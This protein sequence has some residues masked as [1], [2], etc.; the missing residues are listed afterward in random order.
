MRSKPGRE[1]ALIHLFLSA[2]EDGAWAD[3]AWDPVERHTPGTVEGIATRSDGSTLAIEHTLI[4][5]FK[6]DKAD[7]A[8]FERAL[9]KIEQDRS[10]VIRE[11]STEVFVP[12]GTL[13]TGDDWS[14]IAA[15]IHQWLRTSVHTFTE[16]EFDYPCRVRTSNDTLT[17]PVRVKV[18][19]TNGADEGFFLLRRQQMRDD[20]G[21][22]VERALRTKLPKLVKAPANRRV[23]MLERDHMQLDPRRI[24]QEVE[25]LR[26]VVPD[27]AQVSAV[28]IIDTVSFGEPKYVAF[29]RYEGKLVVETLEF[30]G[31]RLTGKSWNGMPVWIDR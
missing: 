8:R 22:V 10:L 31:D 20:L 1:D 27:L 16:G 23:L 28:W 14:R 24:W 9:L 30:T 5:P 19:H 2:Y 13:R 17:L 11:R 6:G 29:R 18:V 26:P 4:E 7:F 25:R 12:V 3:A 15:D 21:D